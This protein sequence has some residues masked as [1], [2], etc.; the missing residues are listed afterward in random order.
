MCE[1]PLYRAQADMLADLRERVAHLEALTDPAVPFAPWEWALDRPQAILAHCLAR[2]PVEA[3]RA[4]MSLDLGMEG[5]THDAR[6]VAAL[7][8][9]LAHRL[10]EWG[11]LVR[12]GTPAGRPARLSD[13]HALHPDQLTAFRAALRGEGDP[14][15]PPIA[16]RPIPPGA[17]AY[18]RKEAVS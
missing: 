15:A 1:C 12:S 9:G 16:H 10:I 6:T 7:V 13:T 5:R 8:A 3:A 4:A 2:G 14:G 11:W 18:R 17:R